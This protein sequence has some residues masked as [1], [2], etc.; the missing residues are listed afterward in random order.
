MKKLFKLPLLLVM[1][2][3]AG[4]NIVDDLKVLQDEFEDFQIVIGTPEFN[5]LVKVEIVDAKT[6]EFITGKTVSVRVSGKNAT[7]VYSNLGTRETS[8]T[9]NHGLILLVIDPKAVDTVAMRTTPIEFDLIVSAEGYTST[10][11]RVFLHEATLNTALIRLIN[12][13]DAP[14]GVSI[15][16]NSTYAVAGLNGQTVAPAVQSMNLGQQTVTIAPGVVLRDATGAPVS[17]TIKSEIVYF[18]PVSESAQN[19][20]PGGTNVSATLPDGSEGQIEFVSAGMFSVNLSAGGREVKTF[21]NGGITLRTVV[22]P[23]LINPNTG[24]P[25]K[26]G[27][28]IEMWSREKESG[29]WVYEKTATV[30][31]ENG[32]LVLEETV[33]HLSYWNWDFF[34]NSCTMGTKFIFEG[35]V[36]GHYPFAKVSSRLQN[37]SFDRVSFTNVRNGFLQL[38]NVPNNVSATFRFEDAGWDP[39]RPLTFSPATVNVAN[40]CSNEPITITVTEAVSAPAETITVNLDLAA[41]AASNSQFVIRPNAYIY[42]RPANIP[43]WSYFYL[44]NGKSQVQ[45]EL[46]TTYELLGYFGNSYGYGSLR[47]DKQGTNQ[48]LVTI[49]PTIN[50]SGGSQSTTESFVVDRPANDIIEIKYNAVLPDRLMNQLR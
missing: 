26:V 31:F 45:F 39:S 6:N 33:T 14:Q 35:D 25:I 9:T 40:L 15:A 49:T 38:Y 41:T 46:G 50:F 27:D 28:E 11:Q 5:T 22:P 29:E 37:A 4:C 13:N 2:L 8:Y 7:D 16:V 3:F 43:R 48:L 24:Q 21:E 32:D 34:Y 19:A 44:F 20:F 23:T 10:T 17:G 47:V 36:T 1:L 42:F 12:I 30:K 18:D